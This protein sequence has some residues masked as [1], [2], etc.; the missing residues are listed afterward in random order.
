MI[1]NEVKNIKT[2]NET[3]DWDNLLD[4]IHHRRNVNNRYIASKIQNFIKD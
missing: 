3:F 1:E 4:E 2:E